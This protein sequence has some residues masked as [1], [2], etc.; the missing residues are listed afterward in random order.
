MLEQ[1]GF[2]VVVATNFVDIQQKCVD[3]N[4]SCILIG[5]NIEPRIKRA[6]GKLLEEVCP[7]TPLLEICRITPEIEEASFVCSDAPEDLLAALDDL[8]KPYGR[9]YTEQLCRRTKAILGR[10]A[11]SVALAREMRARIRHTRASTPKRDNS[12]QKDPS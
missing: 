7:Q 4:I 5:M 11:E 12:R 2:S 3:K 9:R 10:A 1:H 6:I 8:L